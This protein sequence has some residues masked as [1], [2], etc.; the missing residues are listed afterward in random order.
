M[1]GSAGWPRPPD[2]RRLA[3][4][5]DDRTVRVWRVDDEQGEVIGVHRDG[6]TGLA[7]LPDG[8]PPDRNLSGHVRRFGRHS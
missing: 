4:C 6:V 2:G 7:W 5:S 8:R 1:G 3:S